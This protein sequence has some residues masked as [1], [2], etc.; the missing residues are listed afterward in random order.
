[1]GGAGMLESLVGLDFFVLCKQSLGK[2]FRPR[3]KTFMESH[4]Q[5]LNDQVACKI[6]LSELVDPRIL[7]CLHVYCKK[8]IEGIRLRLIADRYVCPAPQ[9]HDEQ[10]IPNLD[11]LPRHSVVNTKKQHIRILR[12]MSKEEVPC[13][14][15][16]P[17]S[18]ASA[19]YVCMHC[20]EGEQI[21]CE[22]C[23]QDHKTR[24]ELREHS[25]DL[26]STWLDAQNSRRLLGRAAKHQP[27]ICSDHGYQLRYYCTNCNT[28][29][30][31]ECLKAR[32]CDKDHPGAVRVVENAVEG[33]K[34]I[35]TRQL[36]GVQAARKEFQAAAKD[37]ENVRER[38]QNQEDQRKMDIN[39]GFVRVRK[40]LD[41]RQKSMLE[42]LKSMSDA[43]RNKLGIQLRQL[44]G[45]A[46]LATRLEALMNDIVKAPNLAHLLALTDFLVLKSHELEKSRASVKKT[47]TLSPL[48]LQSS[49]PSLTPCESPTLAVQIPTNIFQT[50]LRNLWN[51]YSNDADIQKSTAR[52]PGLK[53]PRAL[54][55]TYFKVFLR[56]SKDDPCNQTSGL[57]VKCYGQIQQIEEHVRLTTAS[58]GIVQVSYTPR[59]SIEYKISV[60]I[61]GENIK[62]SPFTVLVQ[63]A[64]VLL[65]DL[66]PKLLNSLEEIVEPVYIAIGPDGMIYVVSQDGMIQKFDQTG[67]S[68][69]NFE[70]G[71]TKCPGGTAIAGDSSLLVT[72][73]EY[74]CISKFTQ[75]GA[76]VATQG[77]RGH[78]DGDFDCPEG[79]FFKSST[80]EVFVCD[81]NNHRVQVFD[82]NL[83]YLRKFVI[84]LTNKGFE[85][86]SEPTDIV[87]NSWGPLYIIDQANNS[88]LMYSSDETFQFSLGPKLDP[89]SRILKTPRCIVTD[90]D[91]IIY[92]SD[93]GCILALQ[94]NG[95]HI[96]TF[97]DDSLILE[98]VG[99]AVD[100]DGHVY[101][102]DTRKNTIKVFKDTIVKV[103]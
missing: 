63:P 100:N 17:A 74:H 88:I 23:S 9:C 70:E 89:S 90:V 5:S 14:L 91:D 24:P 22:G 41:T 57:S 58:Q 50:A 101:V 20:N 16:P 93:S 60:Q 79:V 13:Q 56:D 78:G 80:R 6:C 69:G 51:V 84:D 75:N 25:L 76:L 45:L 44:E 3:T 64:A 92:V 32:R 37:V 87:I 97:E 103:T 21:I 96:A 48:R 35:V 8:C 59:T 83:K 28:T 53:T 102:C 31:F 33:A 12:Q 73:R 54:E 43:K 52:G 82:E 46:N 85:K 49:T 7:P 27:K 98:P 62:G 18:P 42:Q 4:I 34:N 81:K 38:L 40:E 11:D 1:M 67:R 95:D 71:A 15:C 39:T 99:L 55:M 66:Q 47:A 2:M 26:L 29:D 94:S 68:G 65:A 30:C 72:S 19:M 77:K 36:V 61:G 10:V 86:Q